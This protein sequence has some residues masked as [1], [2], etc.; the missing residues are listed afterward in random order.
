MGF[1]WWFIGVLRRGREGS[2][3][4]ESVTIVEFGCG[5]GSG[6]GGGEVAREEEHGG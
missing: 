4:L 3:W 5:G 6:G 2:W 1:R